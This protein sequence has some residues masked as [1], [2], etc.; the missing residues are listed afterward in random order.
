[1]EAD[2][3]TE[4]QPEEKKAIDAQIAKLENQNKIAGLFKYGRDTTGLEKNLLASSSK[5]AENRGIVL[6][7]PDKQKFN[8]FKHKSKRKFGKGKRKDVFAIGLNQFN[9]QQEVKN[10]NQVLPMNNSRSDSKMG[11][12]GN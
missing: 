7:N 8:R 6:D 4:I 5:K 11:L 2:E 10:L 3:N 12:V 1:M 9:K